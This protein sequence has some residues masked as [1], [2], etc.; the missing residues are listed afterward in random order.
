MTDVTPRQAKRGVF[1][2][3]RDMRRIMCDHTTHITPRF[4]HAPHKY[5]E[6]LKVL[7][8]AENKTILI[9]NIHYLS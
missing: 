7:I 4:R 6:I 3:P 8:F 2:Q 9:K 5:F 1:T